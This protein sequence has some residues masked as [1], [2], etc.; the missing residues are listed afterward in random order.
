MSCAFSRQR[1]LWINED[2][3]LR[4]LKPQAYGY[5]WMRCSVSVDN[6]YVDRPQSCYFSHELQAVILL[7]TFPG[8]I[9]AATA[10]E[11]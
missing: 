9:L 4:S 6:P 10:I 11:S 3:G 2:A 1:P 5:H 8:Y 7:G